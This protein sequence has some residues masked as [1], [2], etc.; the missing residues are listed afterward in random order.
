MGPMQMTDLAA[1]R[2]MMVDSQVRTNDVT[3]PR[4][5][6]AMLDVPR[7][8]FVPPAQAALAYLDRDIA[9]GAGM[10]ATP[11]RYLVKPMVL[12]KLIALAEVGSGD[13]VLDVG[14]ATG[15]SMAVLAHIAKSVVA[16]E[17]RGD[18]AR[19]AARHL[20]DL[21][22]THA[23]V[24]EGPLSAGWPSGAPYDVILLNGATEIVPRALLDQL[25]PTGRLVA[26]TGRGPAGKAKLFQNIGGIAS[27]RIGFDA[28]AALLPG[29]AAP[30]EF[31]F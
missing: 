2:R 10:P 22:L 31:V 29:F 23:R 5:V 15:Y 17:E 28:S 14:C 11:T 7:E 4:I 30:A 1:A 21:G 8:R 16:L 13:N 12:A 18:L 24:V 25:S 6:A 9:V 27:E 20:R 26:V 3:D 19:E